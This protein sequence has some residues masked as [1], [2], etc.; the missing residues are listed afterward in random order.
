MYNKCVKEGTGK[1]TSENKS[2]LTN[3]KISNLPSHEGFVTL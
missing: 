2:F 1:K 3:P